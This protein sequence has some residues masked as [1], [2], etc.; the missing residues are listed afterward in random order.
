M[1]E[2]TFN[3]Y[4]LEALD[5]LPE[6]FKQ[7]LHN[8]EF[9]VEDEPDSDQRMQLK[10]RNTDSLYGLYTGVPQTIPGEERA[11][12]PDR[13]TLFRLPIVHS[14]ETEA[15]V[16]QQIKDTLYHEI[17]HYFGIDEAKLRKL[18]RDQ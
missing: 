15:G 4:V 7:Q 18:Q 17:G 12:M 6:E 11:T 13:I 3:S 9:L 8:V 10:L 2:V 14:H 16:K 5:E 1:D